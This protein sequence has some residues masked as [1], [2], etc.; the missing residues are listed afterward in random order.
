MFF[1]LRV[2]LLIVLLA[3]IYLSLCKRVQT[4]RFWKRSREIPVEPRE[5]VFSQAIV[6]L[7]ATAGG[8]YLALLLVRNF[9]QI[10]IPE[11]VVIFGLRFE[12]M[13]AISLLIAI[14]QPYFVFISRRPS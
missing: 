3:L 13:A 6:D 5:S 7:L 2:L 9:L 4:D 10:T 11:Q 8:V 1:V 14:L 12:P